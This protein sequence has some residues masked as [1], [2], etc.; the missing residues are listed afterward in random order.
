M[1]NFKRI[2]PRMLALLLTAALLPG[3]G[4]LA[5]QP[6]ETAPVAAIYTTGD[7]MGKL[8]A[9]N[10]LTGETEQASYLKVATAMAQERSMVESTLLLDSG[11]AVYTGLTGDNGQTVADV[12][13]RIGYDALVPGVEEFRL[14]VGYCG[15]FLQALGEEEGDGAPVDV[16]SA[17][18]LDGEDLEPEAQ[19]YQVYTLP[20]GDAEVRV[21]VLGLG[22]IDAS[23][24]LPQRLYGE[25]L[26]AHPD[27]EELTYA[28]EWAYWQE[29][30]EQEDCDLV[31]VV[32]H[33]DAETVEQ[34]AADTSGIDLLVG[35]HGEAG[36][37]DF[38]NKDGEMVPYVSG[39][40]TALTRTF[41]AMDAEGTPVVRDSALLELKYYENDTALMQ[42]VSPSGVEM[43]KAGTARVGT[44]SGTWEG[45]R[46]LTRQTDTGDLIGEAMLWASG[47]D[48]ALICP[49][50]LGQVTPADLFERKSSTATLTLGDCAKIAPDPSP[51]VTVELTGAQLR[52]WLDTCAER[53]TVTD[54][55][56]PAGGEQA[57]ILYG[58]DYEVYL[59]SVSG[60]R[61]KG[62]SIEGKPVTDDE[63]VTVA[64]MASRL[65]DEEF[66]ACTV[67]WSAAADRDFASR[68]GSTAALLAAYAADATS[69]SRTISPTRS[70]TWAIY[71]GA[72][73]A[74]LTRLEFVEMLYEV[75][76]R[77]QPGADVAFIDVE[78]SNAVIWA[79]EAGVVSGDGKGN[80]LPLTVV[81]REQ[82]A[83]MIYNYV[84]SLD[85]EMPQS[86]GMVEELLDAPAVSPWAVP[87][88]E[89]CLATQILP[90]AG[91]RDDLFLPA[92]PIT[93]VEAGF[94]LAALEDYLA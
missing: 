18:L 88:V 34:F 54:A 29:E 89:F 49:G 63:T 47:A 38:R 4:A 36:V 37:D 66:P 10:P 69:H 72:Y 24:Q 43:E 82:A 31:L 91:V 39:G 27:N 59:G 32:C 25:T 21:G 74:S 30:L 50:A 40:G 19:P 22:G 64:V 11:D 23:R 33:A 46:S 58:I 94:Y 70:S 15:A 76:G 78:H 20:L 12:L 35:G 83:V 80:F 9:K 68:G 61:V 14:G 17:N 73:N 79:A 65:E 2:L 71:A 93:R 84:R 75:A 16:L 3:G 6:E 81:T 60:Q 48:A 92:T 90:A 51:V 41:I 52:Q 85:V 55:G 86:Q 45:S 57:D 8:Y 77:P 53:Y 62:L 56:Q 5:A 13:R 42:A 67:T 44:L 1:A 87:A 28:W 7:M 26:F